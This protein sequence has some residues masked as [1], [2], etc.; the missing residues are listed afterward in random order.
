M[1]PSGLWLFPGAEESVAKWRKLNDCDGPA[2]NQGK[3]S[4]DYKVFG[5]ETS[6]TLWQ[7]CKQGV[8]VG[9]WKMS[10]STHVP[11]FTGAFPKDVVAYLL[12]RT[13]Q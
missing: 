5:N 8:E 1:P 2:T 11:V 10:F 3:V 13:R 7:G 4:Y 6:R 9:L 12:A